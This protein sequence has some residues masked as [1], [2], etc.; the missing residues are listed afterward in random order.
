MKTNFIRIVLLAILGL[1]HYSEAIFYLYDRVN[2]RQITYYYTD[3]GNIF[4]TS[5]NFHS[6]EYAKRNKTNNTSICSFGK[7]V[8]SSRSLP[9]MR[10][11]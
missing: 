2:N 5:D 7:K 1:A 3:A 6:L 4:Y 10:L 9:I 8:N 11:A